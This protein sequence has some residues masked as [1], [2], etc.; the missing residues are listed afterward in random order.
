MLTLTDTQLALLMAA[1]ST[2]PRHQ[3]D[4]FLRRVAECI[5]QGETQCETSPMMKIPSTEMVF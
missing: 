3:R 2:L 5:N 4:H 1:A